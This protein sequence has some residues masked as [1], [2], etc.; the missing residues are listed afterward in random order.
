MSPDSVTGGVVELEGQLNKDRPAA[1]YRLLAFKR[2]IEALL[3]DDAAR[4][5]LMTELGVSKDGG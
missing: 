5:K 1:A 2:K 4:E 3:K